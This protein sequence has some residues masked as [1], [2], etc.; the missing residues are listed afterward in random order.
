M[1]RF[2]IVFGAGGLGCGARYLVNLWVGERS[3]PVATLIVNVVGSFA[4]GLAIALSLRLADFPANLRLAITTGFLG[5]LTTYSAFN[6]ESTT[7]ALGGDYLR[8]FANV[9]ITLVACAAAGLLG[10]ALARALT[11]AS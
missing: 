10:L 5:G 4:M 7:L 11:A 2:L 9:A 1:T 8:A 6:S 3:F